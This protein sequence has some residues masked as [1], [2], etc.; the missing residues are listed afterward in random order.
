MTLPQLVNVIGIENELFSLDIKLQ[1]HGLEINIVT[2]AC[3]V[4]EHGFEVN[5]I[6]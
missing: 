1:I 2:G 4:T 3:E 5:A 6:K